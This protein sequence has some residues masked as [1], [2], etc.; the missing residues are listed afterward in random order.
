[1]QFRNGKHEGNEHGAAEAK[2]QL[3]KIFKCSN[4]QYMS[5]LWHSFP[6]VL[7]WMVPR[8]SSGQKRAAD[9]RCALLA[10]VKWFPGRKLWSMVTNVLL[11]D[12]YQSCIGHY[13]IFISCLGPGTFF[14]LWASRLTPFQRCQNCKRAIRPGLTFTLGGSN[15]SIF[16]VH[17]LLK[18]DKHCVEFY[19]SGLLPVLK[20]DQVQRNFRTWEN[21]AAATSPVWSLTTCTSSVKL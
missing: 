13:D 21:L 15:F 12:P 8:T 1:M 9:H 16:L 6:C 2:N 4:F 20:W 11:I 18:G 19:V 3:I 7:L 5:H 10:A 17:F 14:R